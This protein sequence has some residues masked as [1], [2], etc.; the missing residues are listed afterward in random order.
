MRFRCL[1]LLWWLLSEISK[2]TLPK[3]RKLTVFWDELVVGCCKWQLTREEFIF[4]R[5]T[6]T[7]IA[8]FFFDDYFYPLFGFEE[9]VMRLNHFPSNLIPTNLEVPNWMCF[10]FMM[11]AMRV[12]GIERTLICMF[13]I[14][15]TSS[16]NIWNIYCVWEQ[17]FFE[18][19]WSFFSWLQYLS[20]VGWCR[21]HRHSHSTRCRFRA[22]KRAK[23][24]KQF[25]ENL[26]EYFTFSMWV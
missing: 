23:N 8:L 14:T 12:R 20:C 6:L 10:P 4:G 3:W 17:Y 1:F 9:K 24:I 15:Q 7:W 26:G 13:E 16:L 11:R 18:C 5:V 25:S 22:N 2:M 19:Q 21:H